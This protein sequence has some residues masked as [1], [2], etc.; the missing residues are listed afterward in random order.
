ML[1]P[2]AAVLA[3]TEFVGPEVDI[4]EQLFPTATGVAR[5]SGIAVIPRGIAKDRAMAPP[6]PWISVT[7]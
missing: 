2:L 3:A 7:G 1:R 4:M 6:P 5:L